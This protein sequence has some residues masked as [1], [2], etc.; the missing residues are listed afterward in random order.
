[1]ADHAL[2]V[3]ALAAPAGDF[4]AGW[5]VIAV[6]AAVVVVSCWRFLLWLLA[7]AVIALGCLGL[8]SLLAEPPAAA[9]PEA[10][11][12]SRTQVSP[13]PAP[14]PDPASEAARSGGR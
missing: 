5:L 2:F 8:V 14:A 3:S 1:M 4:R 13:P 9:G 6:I 11:P 10:P 12:A 7:V